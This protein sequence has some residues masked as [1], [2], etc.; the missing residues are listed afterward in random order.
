MNV[1]QNHQC[2][3]WDCDKSVSASHFLC[4]EHYQLHQDNLIDKCQ[5]CGKYKDA[6]Y[7]LCLLCRR[8]MK[9]APVPHS[10]K[11][12]ARQSVEHNG[13]VTDDL[14]DDFYVYIMK[15]DGGD[16]YVGQTGDLRARVMEHR[17][18]QVAGT[19]GKNPSLVWFDF[20]ASRQEALQLEIHVKQLKDGNPRG[21][22]RLILRFGDLVREVGQ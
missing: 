13:Q 5:A 9:S 19:A 6:K 4:L 10:L 17:D 8:K 20:I 11:Q 3:Y 18:G 2:A 1:T 22:R 15:L 21:F 16:Y 7:E 12:A 14:S